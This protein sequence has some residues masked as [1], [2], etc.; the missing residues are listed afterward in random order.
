[1][2]ASIKRSSHHEAEVVSLFPLTVVLVLAAGDLTMFTDTSSSKLNL[3]VL[4][5]GQA[6]DIS[7]VIAPL[8][9]LLGDE[10]RQNLR[11]DG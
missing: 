5:R 3:F 7:H 2:L 4:A 8:G 1:L 11:F 6:A 9:L 10:E